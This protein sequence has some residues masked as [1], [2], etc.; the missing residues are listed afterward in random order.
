[1]TSTVCR[2][3][4]AVALFF[5]LGSFGVP[6][7]T[8]AH[9][10][11]NFSINHYSALHLTPEALEVR[12]ILDL[13]EIPT[14]QVMQASAL[15]ATAGHP[16]IAAYLEQQGQSLRDG[17]SLTLNDQPLPLTL[18]T[19]EALFPAGAGGLP[20]LKLS[21]VYRAS[22]PV[23]TPQMTYTLAYHDKNFAGR[24]GWQEIIA[25]AGTD[26][27]FIQSS[28]PT[29][30]R[31]RALTDYPTDVLNSPPQT[32]EATV[33]FQYVGGLPL[34]S[35]TTTTPAVQEPGAPLGLAANR[36]GTPRNAFTEL[37]V[38]PQ[39]SAGVIALAL[40]IAA[41]LG[42]LHGLEPGHGKTVVAAY[43]V[44]TRGTARHALYL[45]LIVTATHTAGVYVLGLIALYA[46]H[47]IVPEQLYPWLGS[48][49]GLA[50]ACLGGYLLCQRYAAV[51]H[52][53]GRS[54]THTHGP[55]SHHHHAH[56]EHS[57]THLYAHSHVHSQEPMHTDAAH[58]QVHTP[59]HAPHQHGHFHQQSPAH[60]A[61]AAVSA[62]ALFTLGIT[63]GIVPCPAAVVVLLSAVAMHRIG[64]GLLL[65]LAF[66]AGLAA[67]L[68]LIGLLMVYA[69]QLMSHFQGEGPLLRRWLPLASAALVTLFGI[70]MML[71]AL[72]SAG[73]ITIRL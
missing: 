6:S 23:L 37:V 27:V 58:G 72:T 57:Q 71:Q 60:Q 55:G 38:A 10:L 68:I 31:S 44:G 35:A 21:V 5:L 18:M 45:G 22:Y 39:R 46:S 17:L 24:T 61:D 36:Q 59:E 67:V 73:I 26:V 51:P 64:F 15:V 12:Y 42:A 29:T 33:L 2:R 43:L 53:H 14:F 41:G 52:Q 54:H 32:L 49:S 65:I 1:M 3:S 40:A 19:S 16:S 13:A 25:T 63:G 47:Y 34:P 28:V 66:S 7:Q 56:L 8:G 69:R 11:G 9:P 4:T 70:V 20:T 50:I 30:D 48:L 62:R